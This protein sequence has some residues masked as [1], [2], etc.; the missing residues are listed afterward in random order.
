MPPVPP[1]RDRHRQQLSLLTVCLFA[2]GFEAVVVYVILAV[3]EHNWVGAGIALGM[4][5]LYLALWANAGD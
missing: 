4:L 2:A 1:D 5:P 3:V